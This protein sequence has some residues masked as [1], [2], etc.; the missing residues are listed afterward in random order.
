VSSREREDTGKGKGA[1]KKEIGRGYGTDFVQKAQ[2][3]EKGR[4]ESE[5]KPWAQKNARTRRGEIG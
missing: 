2:G 3:T 1:E 5:S 4:A